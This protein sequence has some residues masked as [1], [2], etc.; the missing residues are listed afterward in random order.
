MPMVQV[1]MLMGRSPDQKR[2]LAREITDLLAR[3][4]ECDPMTV[5]VIFL[6][7]ALGDWAVG[8]VLE[9]DRQSASAAE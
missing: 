1:L 5:R 7:F 9:S 2:R 8:G 3:V 4:T 6:D